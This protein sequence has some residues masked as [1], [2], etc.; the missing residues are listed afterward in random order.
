M[1]SE[2]VEV[3]LDRKSTVA[4]ANRKLNKLASDQSKLRCLAFKWA[5]FLG[6][7]ENILIKD[8]KDCNFN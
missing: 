2:F 5:T 7:E 6:F 8:F 4:V 1:L 3:S